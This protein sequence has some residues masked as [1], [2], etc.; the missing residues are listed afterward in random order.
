MERDR[1]RALDAGLTRRR[2]LGAVTAS[3][4]AIS[5]GGILAACGDDDD[6]ESTGQP[7]R[8]GV[9]TV[10]LAGGSPTDTLDAHTP[11]SSAAV[12]RN[13]QL[14]EGLAA[15]T[16]D[17]KVTN[18][19]AEELTPSNG[20][21]LWTARIKKDAVFHDGQ[22]VTAD[23]VIFSLRRIGD[24]KAPKNS[25]PLIAEV[26][27]NAL[28]KVDER[29][30]EIPMKRPFAVLPESLSEVSAKIVPA[31]YDPKNPIGAGPFKYKSFTPGERTVLE[32]FPDYVGDVPLVDELV[33]VDLPDD[34]ARVNALLG[35]DVDLIDAVP[36]GQI[37]V[38]E[39][40][41]GLVIENVRSGAWRTL[42][43]NMSKAP[44]TDVRVR[45]A[46]RLIANRQEIV[47]QAYVGQAVVAADVH[48]RFQAC[49]ASDL[50]RE[51]DIE[52]AKSLLSQAGEDKLRVELAASAVSA[53][54]VETCQVF[55]EQAKAAGVTVSVRK[56]DPGSFFANYGKWTFG[57]D[58]WPGRPL[59][60]QDALGNL[61]DAPLNPQHWDDKEYTALYRR[62]SSELD[63]DRRCEILHEMQ[64]ILYDRGALLIPTFANAVDARRKSVGGFVPDRSGW[65]ANRW[66]YNLVGFTS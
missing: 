12:A 11:L 45:Q 3:G 30:V 41:S 56:L 28:R 16:P 63:E 61:P 47:D 19:L 23:D 40:D 4:V 57:V 59:L 53:G 58:Y 27:L 29:T 14:N 13:L 60:N 17:S 65:S 51:Q 7:R 9:L 66:R 32:R 42:T 52:Q 21:R 35:G 33:L 24:P 34:T 31:D 20:G 62:A 46:F 10:G 64:Q 54:V 55:A 50:S 38:V 36:Y 15:T 5:G 39:G 22:P 48:G 43:M 1:S 18:S 44:F 6:S 25:A 37:R 8:G 2:F 49:H 26:D